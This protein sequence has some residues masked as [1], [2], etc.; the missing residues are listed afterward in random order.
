MKF[1]T[2]SYELVF[3]RVAASEWNTSEGR[4][5]DKDIPGVLLIEQK[6]VKRVKMKE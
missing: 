2:Y 5:M 4:N 1:V 3:G 6:M